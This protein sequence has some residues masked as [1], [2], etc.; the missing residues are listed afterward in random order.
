MGIRD[1]YYIVKDEQQAIDDLKDRILMLLTAATSTTKSMTTNQG[2]R[3]IGGTK[4]RNAKIMLKVIELEDQLA[5]MGYK[6]RLSRVALIQSV[7]K[8]P[9]KAKPVFVKKYCKD[10][11]LNQIAKAQNQTKQNI[12]KILKNYEKNT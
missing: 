10:M 6:H 2:G 8:V 5:E 7:S 12:C 3:V 11:S 4:D 9:E 1:D